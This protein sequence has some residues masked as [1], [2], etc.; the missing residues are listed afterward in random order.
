MNAKAKPNR[1]SR[2]MHRLGPARL[3]ALATVLSIAT[4]VS[5]AQAGGLMEEVFNVRQEIS[6]PQFGGSYSE[7]LSID[8]FDTQGGTRQLLGMTF[9][10][11]LGDDV[12]VTVGDNL[13]T[14]DFVG[15]EG[16]WDIQWTASILGEQILPDP[17]G[18]F[19]EI[20]SNVSFGFFAGPLQPGFVFLSSGGIGLT[21]LISNAASL[22]TFTGATPLQLDSNFTMSDLVK[23]AIPPEIEPG[24]VF[25]PELLD[26]QPQLLIM[27]LTVT[28]SWIPVPEPA[29]LCLLG[30][31][32]LLVVRR[33]R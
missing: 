19:P 24:T 3:A 2:G 11:F 29:S 9:D 8:R 22:S 33:R 14:T 27:D 17:A 31:G 13:S 10:Y 6:D 12:L 26:F 23:Q 15:A 18:P 4:T 20:D 32:G 16:I 25:A 28:Y 21:E 5:Q 7:P 30:F 1:N